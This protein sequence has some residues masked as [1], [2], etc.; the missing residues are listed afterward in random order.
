M[1][2]V[3]TL[4]NRETGKVVQTSLGYLRPWFAKGFV[5]IGVEKEAE[6]KK[7]S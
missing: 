1:G 3:I 4:K 6:D 5:V 7:A 2:Y